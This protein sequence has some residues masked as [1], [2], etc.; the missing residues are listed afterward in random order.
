MEEK[1]DFMAPRSLASVL[2]LY[3]QHLLS[4][5]LTFETAEKTY[6]D[7]LRSFWYYVLRSWGGPSPKKQQP[8]LD[9]VE[10]AWQFMENVPLS[11]I[12]DALAV[13]EEV[14]QELQVSGYCKQRYGFK[15]RQLL[16]WS[17]EQEWWPYPVASKP[18]KN[19]APPYDH[20]HGA[21]GS[22]SVS[23]RVNLPPYALRKED[24]PAEL[25]QQLDQVHNFFTAAHQPGRP[26]GPIKPEVANHYIQYIREVLGWF[27]LHARPVYDNQGRVIALS[28]DER[29]PL[30]K[31]EELSLDLLIPKVALRHRN[32]NPLLEQEAEQATEYIDAWICHLLNFLEIE[33]Q[34]N[35]RSS[36][37]VLAGIHALARFQYHKDT[38]DSKYR[39]I[40]VLRI[41]RGHQ[42]ELNARM[43][44]E[45]AASNLEMQWLE[46][47]EILE[48]IVKPLR[49]GCAYR[50]CTGHLR[51]I[52]V[53]AHSFQLFLMWACLTFRPPRRQQEFR[54]LQIGLACPIQRPKNLKQRQ[55]IHP[56]PSDR[57]EHRSHGYLYKADDGYWYMDMTPESYKTGA[58]YGHQKLAIPNPPLADGKGLYDYL[59]AFLYGYYRD[60]QGNWQSGGQLAETPDSNGEWYS[61]RMAF[62]PTHNHVFCQPKVGG[63][64]DHSQFCKL[65]RTSSNRL[66]GQRV[67]PHLLRDIVATWFLINQYTVENIQSLAYAMGHSEEML[68]KLY[69]RR[70]TQQKNQPIEDALTPVVQKFIA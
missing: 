1:P 46:L 51:P 19:W 22:E 11:K 8:Q 5:E 4:D 6:H 42:R 32:S 31:V 17:Q 27:L 13:Q 45:D 30:I 23:S 50:T 66:T 10:A 56:L 41:V 62:E 25:Q 60:R 49:E 35:S 7:T 54:N 58:K 15:L 36:Y 14:F 48:K 16:Q 9:E 68:R 69:D 63:I 61:L 34:H 39:D 52:T 43:K 65:I 3:Q 55:F 59:E 29:V 53:I 67:F 57:N 24:T 20:G 37:S 18:P 12:Q 28:Q 70:T 26:T 64:L 21:V 33:R 2:V 38:A 44:I 40:P 47:P